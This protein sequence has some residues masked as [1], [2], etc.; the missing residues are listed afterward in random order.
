MD[1]FN[2]TERPLAEQRK[3]CTEVL[4]LFIS[5]CIAFGSVDLLRAEIFFLKCI[6]SWVL[7]GSL[8]WLPP[9]AQHI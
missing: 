6:T 1:G 3:Y 8:F 5:D 4:K 2:L 7:A 9:E